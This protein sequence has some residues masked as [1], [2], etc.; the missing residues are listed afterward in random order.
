[1]EVHP[2]ALALARGCVHVTANGS[3]GSN[4]A[5][6]SSKKPI[7]DTSPIDRIRAE[8][9]RM[10]AVNRES[11]TIPKVKSGTER[12][13]SISA[14]PETINERTRVY[15][16][17]GRDPTNEI[18]DPDK[19][20][21]RVCINLIRAN[22]SD[23]LIYGILVDD[24][25]EISKYVLAQDEIERYVLRQIRRGREYAQ[26][27]RLLELNEKHAVIENHGGCCRV[28]EDPGNE[29]SLDLSLI[30]I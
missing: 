10:S 5:N 1:M 30:H 18:E 20:V 25:Y 24:R 7:D 3:N 12:L 6:G 16:A 15:I 27:K 2:L 22:V 28:M 19:L 29:E 11:P 4:G 14:L 17:Q 21:V 26:D 13:K 23:E 8:I 9:R